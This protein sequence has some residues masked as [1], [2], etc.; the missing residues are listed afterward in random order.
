MGRRVGGALGEVGEDM[1]DSF[2][3]A[4]AVRMGRAGT[5]EVERGVEAGIGVLGGIGV[6]VGSAIAAG[7][8]SLNPVGKY[9]RRRRWRWDGGGIVMGRRGAIGRSQGALGVAWMG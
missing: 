7:G 5:G 6:F 4:L 8:W 1:V 9:G 3:T 2:K